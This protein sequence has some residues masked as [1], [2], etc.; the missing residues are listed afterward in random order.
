MLLDCQRL[1][2]NIQ[3]PSER[4]Q[5]R[6]LIGWCLHTPAH[7]HTESPQSTQLIEERRLSHRNREVSLSL[8][9]AF[10]S[11]APYSSGCQLGADAL[12]GDYS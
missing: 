1:E 6:W 8:L 4:S 9:V 10:L 11:R 3:H 2:L 5:S 12:E 7:T